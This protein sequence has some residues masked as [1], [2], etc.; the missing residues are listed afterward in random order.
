VILMSMTS[1]TSTQAPFRGH[2]ILGFRTTSHHPNQDDNSMNS[3]PADQRASS[4]SHH[5]PFPRLT[6]V[7]NHSRRSREGRYP[8]SMLDSSPGNVEN[9]R[10]TEVTTTMES[11]DSGPNSNARFGGERHDGAVTRLVRVRST[12]RPSS[13]SSP[14]PSA[15]SGGTT[16]GGRDC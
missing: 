6:N 7:T 13:S 11:A 16:V 1:E 12:R 2:I 3:T 9:L 10:L 14:P 5:S 4:S 8:P 15:R